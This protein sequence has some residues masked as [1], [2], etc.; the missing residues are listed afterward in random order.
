MDEDSPTR[1]ASIGA[2]RVRGHRERRRAAGLVEVKVWVREQD[3]PHAHAALRPF[4][5]EAEQ[6]LDRHRRQG[7]TNMVAFE[8]RFPGV[9][10]GQFREQL[11]QTWGLTWDQG[12]RRW[13]GEVEDQLRLDQLRQF[14]A[15]HGGVIEVPIRG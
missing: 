15:A 4:T 10:P 1:P 2:R 9:P 8:L 7:R 11:W 14:V 6:A 5:D 3:V 13:H 12:A